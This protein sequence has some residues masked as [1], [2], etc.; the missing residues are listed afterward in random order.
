M[1]III[2]AAICIYTSGTNMNRY[3][4][5][6]QITDGI[7]GSGGRTLIAGDQHHGSLSG[8]PCRCATPSVCISGGSKDDMPQLLLRSN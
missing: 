4:M 5:Y 8:P 3:I 1:L 6:R 7:G 2:I